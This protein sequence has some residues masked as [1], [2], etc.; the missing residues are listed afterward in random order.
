MIHFRNKRTYYILFALFF[1][2]IEIG[3]AL[4]FHSGF[5]RSYV[6]DFIVVMLLY[7]GLMAITNLEIPNGIVIVLGIA[8]VIELLQ[9]TEF[10]RS[11]GLSGKLI[12]L[13]LGTTFSFMDILM[14]VLGL[15]IIGFTDYQLYVK[16]T[17][18]QDNF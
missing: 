15:T 6:G 1:F 12:K 16:N 5:I 9:L 17:P 7:T 13:I 10:T 2:L 4:F 11:I 3:I 18:L 14:Y 8:I